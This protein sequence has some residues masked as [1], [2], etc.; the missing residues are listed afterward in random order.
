M[1]KI[2]NSQGALANYGLN[3]L[4]AATGGKMRMNV[5]LQQV[6]SVDVSGLSREQM[7]QFLQG[8]EEVQLEVLKQVEDKGGL[9]SAEVRPSINLKTIKPTID[10]T[11]VAQM[12]GLTED[13][14]KDV[15]A[16][17]KEVFAGRKLIGA[18]HRWMARP[19]GS[20]C[21]KCGAETGLLTEDDM[22]SPCSETPGL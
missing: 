20:M 21:K 9:M 5:Y 22:T 8:S 4:R 18:T 1:L 15:F 19:G 13:E 14:A 10:T 2:V 6:R 16:G 11:M 12:T 3:A 17:A 7:D